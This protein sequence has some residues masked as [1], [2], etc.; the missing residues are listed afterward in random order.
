MKTDVHSFWEDRAALGMKAG[1]NDLIAKQLEI[2]AIASY[3]ADGMSVLDFGC[4]NGVT[5]LELARRYE[6]KMLG[7]DYSEKMIEGARELSKSVSTK[8]QVQFV[9]GN[10]TKLR[11]LSEKFDMIYSER[12]LINLENWEAQKA[13]IEVLTDMLVPGGIYVMCENSDDGLRAINT[14]RLSAGLDPIEAPWHNKYIR[15]EDIAELSLK[16]TV[17]ES[18]NHYSSTYYFLSRVVNAWMAAQEGKE[19][20]YNAVVNSLALSLP[21][22]GTFGQGRIWIWR[23]EI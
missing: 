5:A 20:D 15:D 7:I 14:L 9:T 22:I 23:K 2:E 1:S 6:L 11:S 10:V 21:P 16:E 3:A 19:P 13:A 18:V 12:A 17:L 8:G 4:G